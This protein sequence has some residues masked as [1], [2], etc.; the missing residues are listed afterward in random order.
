MV[1][2]ELKYS[3]VFHVDS[4]PRPSSGRIPRP[5]APGRRIMNRPDVRR[6]DRILQDSNVTGYV[7]ALERD[8]FNATMTVAENLCRQM[9]YARGCKSKCPASY[10]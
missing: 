6:L 10:P 1:H 9:L 5:S 7:V 4:L 8:Q 3:N 2:Q